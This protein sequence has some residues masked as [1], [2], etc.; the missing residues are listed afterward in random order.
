MAGYNALLRRIG[1]EYGLDST[2]V[3]RGSEREKYG[4]GVKAKVGVGEDKTE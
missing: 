1:R 4:Y 2:R 3:V